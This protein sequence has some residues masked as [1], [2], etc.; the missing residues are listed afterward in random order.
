MSADVDDLHVGQR[1]QIRFSTL[2][3]RKL[4]LVDGKL[5]S[6]S[7]DSLADEKTGVQY[8][9]AEVSVPEA[10]LAKIKSKQSAHRIQAG[11]PVE[12]LVPLRK[13]SA[14]GYLIEPI[15]QTFWRFGREN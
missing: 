6:V 3:D 12:V 9:T 4:P 8:F 7:A 11:L 2:H 13:R 1:T 14:L 10:E 5:E 15:T